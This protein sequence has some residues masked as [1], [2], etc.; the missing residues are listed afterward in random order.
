MQ[1]QPQNQLEHDIHTVEISI[2]YAK[3]VIALGEAIDRLKANRDFQLVIG[4]T[5][6]R[7]EASRLTLLLGDPALDDKDKANV[8]LALRAI[9]EF[10]QF[11]RVRSGMAEQLRK[12]LL[13][14][15]EQLDALRQI[16]AHGED[17]QVIE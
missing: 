1:K 12:D 10:F 13:D 17:P 8:T 5:Y 11:L 2:D 9:G 3:Q 16:E 6:Q 15:T 7:E 14:Y 4:D